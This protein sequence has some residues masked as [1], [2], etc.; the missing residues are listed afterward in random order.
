MLTHLHSQHIGYGNPARF[1]FFLA[2]T[3]TKNYNKRSIPY[4]FHLSL[5]MN[6]YTARQQDLC[7]IA[8]SIVCLPSTHYVSILFLKPGIKYI[9]AIAFTHYVALKDF[10]S[11]VC[12]SLQLVKSI[13][14]FVVGAGIVSNSNVTN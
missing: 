1:L 7:E 11:L 14:Q 4:D 9:I 12:D 3:T 13:S 8:T 10:P 2:A 5:V 6:L